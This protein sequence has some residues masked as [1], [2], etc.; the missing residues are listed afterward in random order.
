M[1]IPTDSSVRLLST[2]LFQSNG[3]EAP[4]NESLERS[5]YRA[6]SIGRHHGLTIDD[7]LR[8]TPKFWE[9]HM[10][11]IIIRDIVA[12]IIFSIQYNLVAGTI[13]PYAMKRPDLQPVMQKIL[14]FDVCACFMLN[15]V[16]HGCDARSLETTAT[17]Q[18]DG[19]F[20]LHSPTP[21][22]AKFMPPSMP[23][24]GIP[25]I[26][27]VF[28]RLMVGD[29]DRGIRPFMVALGDGKK[30]CNGVTST[31]LPPIACGRTLDHSITS[32]NQ[33]RLPSTAMLGS[34]RKPA[35]M[36]T[37]FLM[38]TNR[39]GFGTL[40][41]SLSAI[42]G[43]RC[44][45]FIVGKYSLRR[46]VVGPEGSP[47]PIISFRTQ[48]LPILHALAET[49]VMEP[50]ANW[51]TT[52]FSD[53][54]LDFSVRHGLAV[55][56]KG[57]VLQYTQKSF[58]NLL[59][60]CG[61]QG[62][63]MHNQLV[64]M[65]ALNRCNGIAE[66][67]ILVLSIRLATEILIG[68]YEIP[69]ATK[70]NTLMVKH[71]EG[72]IADLRKLQRSI[73]EGPRS[74]AYNNRMLPHCRSIVLA[75]GHRMA[76]EAAVD[77]GVDSDLLA[78]YEAGVVKTDSSWYVENLGLNRADQFEMECNAADSLLPRLGELLDGLDA[79]EPYITAPILTAKRWETFLADR[80]TIEGGASFD[81]M[82]AKL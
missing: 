53:T 1:Q 54:S 41:L 78:L 45:T 42:P 56:F 39:L 40:A 44:A 60:R 2:P 10:D 82:Q 55:I 52:K 17:L 65:E 49:A 31:L 76:Y 63:F 68:R 27:V 51:I 15:E 16:D 25:R 29:D 71:E 72:Y 46:T 69:K 32:F 33:V 3:Y 50:F 74:E 58:A 80:E 5:Y 12:H 22:A 9:S 48:Q 73:H 79:M 62:V 81:I 34:P 77:G 61:A 59:E 66:G 57:A 64:E 20:V 36:R 18:S 24:A 19:S 7:I 67:E 8:L 23:I 14:N 11:A 26:A 28:A 30:M 43:L 35:N 13:A 37:Q 38:A 6:R 47:K 21:G 70:P 75:I 4:N